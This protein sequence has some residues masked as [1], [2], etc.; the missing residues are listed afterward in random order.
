MKKRFG[1]IL[2]ACFSLVA[3]TG[4]SIWEGAAGVAAGGDLPASGLY[5]ATNSFPLNTVVDV[6]NLEN[7]RT[8]RVIASAPLETPGLLAMLSRE[9]AGAIGLPE[10]TIGRIRMSQSV[11]PAVSS[12]RGERPP[13]SGDP[14]FDPAAFVALNRFDPPADS[15]AGDERIEGGDLIVDLPAVTPPIDTGAPTDTPPVLVYSP[16][17]EPLPPAADPL[18]P[19]P[20]HTIA[21][22]SAPQP[23]PAAPP[24]EP[25]TVLLMVPAAP[26]P[27]EGS[28]A[29]DP[30]YIIPGVTPPAPVSPPP[31]AAA[32]VD[33]AL[34]IPPVSETPSPRPSPAAIIPPASSLPLISSLEAGKHYVQIAALSSEE[35]VRNLLS[36]IN[37]GLP[38]AVMN[39]GSPEKPLFRVLIGPL[40]LGESGA[41]LQ[42]MQSTHHDAFIRTGP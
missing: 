15:G 33:P 29:P 42:R 1:V 11:E 2:T 34:V 31:E 14:D 23:A 26:R 41:L 38:R 16:P 13:A 17:P 18:P 40:T 3:L 30:A 21:V 12:R 8:I 4:S 24:V 32:F 10:R 39:V 20:E 19:A 6:T 37:S 27:P 28:V 25:G 7:G 9:A 22:E 36:G 35:G 5:I